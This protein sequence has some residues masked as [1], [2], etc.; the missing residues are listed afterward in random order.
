MIDIRRQNI[1]A[2]LIPAVAILN[3]LHDAVGT[4][5][6]PEITNITSSLIT[7]IEVLNLNTLLLS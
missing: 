4:P 1:T 3:D 6:L 7:A 5:F 2:C